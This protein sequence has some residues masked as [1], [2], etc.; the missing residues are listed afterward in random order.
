V[1]LLRVLSARFGNDIGAFEVKRPFGVT[2]TAQARA[3]F[4]AAT[5]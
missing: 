3:P 5:W 4:A 1:K 2:L